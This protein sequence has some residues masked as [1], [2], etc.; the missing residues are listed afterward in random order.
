M[1]ESNSVYAR[2]PV[3]FRVRQTHVSRAL[4]YHV[5]HM[6]PQAVAVWANLGHLRPIVS[7]IKPVFGV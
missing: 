4:F 1:Y 3:C 2:P 6:T 7:S 5:L